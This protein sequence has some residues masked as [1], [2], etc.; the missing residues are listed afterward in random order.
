MI[1][2]DKG[3]GKLKL[4]LHTH[5]FE[6][7]DAVP[8]QE[9]VQ[10]IVEAVRRKGLDG[11]AI[12]EHSSMKFGLQAKE[13][14]DRYLDGAIIII[15]GREI[16]DRG[17]EIVELFLPQGSIFRF[18]AH[19]TSLSPYYPFDDNLHGIEIE[20][21]SHNAAINQEVVRRVAEEN[22][23]L[24]FRNSDA[25]SLLEVGA[26]YNE[27]ELEELNRAVVN[28]KLLTLRRT[29]DWF[30]EELKKRDKIIHEL[31]KENFE[32]REAKNEG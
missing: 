5:C 13:I 12:T 19:P 18:L 9:S 16:M 25:H 27:I 20:N 15:P 7:M 29:L 32:L 28:Q 2:R 24:L 8:D 14:V 22:D 11:I 26:L 4:D 10:A 30:D 17:Q 31:L 3:A 1:G 6:A 23:L 21:Y